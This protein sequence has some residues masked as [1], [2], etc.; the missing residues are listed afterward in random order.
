MYRT[1]LGRSFKLIA[2]AIVFAF[3]VAGCGDEEESATVPTRTAPAASPLV[4]RI[5]ELETTIA[6]YCEI[7]SSGG[8]T[9][10]HRARGLA[11]TDALIQLARRREAARDA[12]ERTSVVIEVDCGDPALQR[13]VDR[14]LASLGG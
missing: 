8:A 2:L 5:A 3:A 11:A 12:L 14:A 1:R 10:E 9:A 13:R 7:R 6:E 4:T